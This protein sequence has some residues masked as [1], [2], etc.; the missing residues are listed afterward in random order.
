M[1]ECKSVVGVFVFT[2]ENYCVEHEFFNNF[3]DFSL[4][5]IVAY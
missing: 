2:C 3:T 4:E 1:E 5:L